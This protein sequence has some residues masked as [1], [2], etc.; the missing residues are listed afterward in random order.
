MD[1]ST[2]R[3]EAKAT[4]HSP[5]SVE[6]DNDAQ[7]N[8]VEGGAYVQAWVWVDADPTAYT[9]YVWRTEQTARPSVRT[10]LVYAM[11][12]AIANSGWYKAQIVDEFGAVTLEVKN[13]R[14]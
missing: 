11:A 1:K 2:A 3:K 14:A 5:G 8:L 9:V 4:Y 13:D 12:Y 6:I 10:G 7:V